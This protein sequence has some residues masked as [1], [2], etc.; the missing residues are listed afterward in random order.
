MITTTLVSSTST[1]IGG[2]HVK[3]TVS[4]V[5]MV[6]FKF[7]GGLIPSVRKIRMKKL[8]CYLYVIKLLLKKARRIDKYF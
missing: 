2:D 4:S 8:A 6:I 5:M 3:V 7:L 1:P